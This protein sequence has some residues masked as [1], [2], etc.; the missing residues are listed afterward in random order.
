VCEQPYLC[1]LNQYGTPVYGSTQNHC[2]IAFKRGRPTNPVSDAEY[3][4]FSQLM[5]AI[6]AG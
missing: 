3:Y 6:A 4:A 1:A 2:A 5:T